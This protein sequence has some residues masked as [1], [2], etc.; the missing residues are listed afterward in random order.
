MGSEPAQTL[1]RD[2]LE[3]RTKKVLNRGNWAN[4][5]VLLVEDHA[6]HLVVIKDFGPRRW[7]VKSTYGKWITA[8]EVAAYRR[9][10]G[11]P[12]VP[13][14]LGSID[15]LALMIE[16]RP[17]VQMS[18]SLA[19]QLPEA[20]MGELRSAV[21]SMHERGVVHLDLRHRSN[22]LADADGHPVLIDFA[23]AVF[24]KPGGFW[25]RILSPILA[26]VD[27]GAVRK[28]EVRVVSPS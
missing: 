25:F 5:D 2:D 1:S 26:R 18:R 22:V 11:S 23:S 4:P 15:D 20:F 3:A 21:A 13:D 14:L 24:F 8:R 27:W 17:G 6:G 28:W 9:L 7:I 12:A 19:G 16:F 10:A